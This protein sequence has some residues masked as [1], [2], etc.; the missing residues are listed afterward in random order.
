VP[1]SKDPEKL[2]GANAS[3]TG[4]PCTR[5][6]VPG[7]PRCPIHGGNA[8]QVRAAGQ[9]RLAEDYA[10]KAVATYGLPVDVS[11]TEALLNEVR[12]TAG[13]V[14]WLRARIQ[15]LEAEYLV[16]GKTKEEDHQATEFPGL[17]VTE[18]AA[19]NVWAQLYMAERKHLVDVCA[20]AL[21]AGVEERFVKLAESQGAL[22][23]SVI[24]AILGDLD[25]TPEQAAKA[26]DVAAR[27][28]RAVA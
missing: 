13:H 27:H 28:L 26:P 11:P 23:A 12:W 2:C 10:R 9:R 21:K 19:I 6:K 7:T 22:L 4:R 24:K 15:D 8:P 25:L 17:N 16:W 5:A 18:T 1:V 3:S 20:A 14:E